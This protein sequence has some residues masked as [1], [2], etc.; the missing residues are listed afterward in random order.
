MQRKLERISGHLI[1]CAYGRVGSQ[2]VQELER[3]GVAVVVVENNPDPVARLAAED[4]RI[5]E[6]RAGA[7]GSGDKC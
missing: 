6:V 2:V 5:G 3:D 4:K 7:S 1:V